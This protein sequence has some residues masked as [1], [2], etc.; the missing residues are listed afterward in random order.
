MSRT[1]HCYAE[2]RDG[3]WEAICLDLDIAVQGDSF[4]EV[5]RALDEAIAAYLETVHDLP[6]S[7]QRHLLRRKAP[8]YVR[9][10][11]LLRAVRTILFGRDSDP[12]YAD[13]TLAAAA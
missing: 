11:F 9:L 8:I 7:E 4:A 6:E 12:Q 13:F 2:G 5:Y 10:S 1:L 3:G